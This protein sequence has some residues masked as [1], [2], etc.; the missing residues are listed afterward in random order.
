M[1]ACVNWERRSP[2]RRTRRL[3]PFSHEAWRLAAPRAPNS[4]AQGRVRETLGDNGN[5]PRALKGRN[6]AHLLRP[7]R[8]RYPNHE[9]PGSR[10]LDPGLTN[11]TPLACMTPPSWLNGYRRLAPRPRKPLD[12]TKLK[13]KKTR[14]RRV[15]RS[16]D[17]PS[18]STRALAML[19]EGEGKSRRVFHRAA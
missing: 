15:G 9:S 3:Y 6:I 4:L 17:R 14:L 16:G 8:A 1:N 11:G 19:R 2:D 7:F 13:K 5:K 12:R 18:Q 10:R